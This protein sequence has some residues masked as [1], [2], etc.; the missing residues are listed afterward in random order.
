MHRTAFPACHRRGDLARR[1]PGKKKIPGSGT[2]PG[3]RPPHQDLEQGDS[4]PPNTQRS[5]MWGSWRRGFPRSGDSEGGRQREERHRNSPTLTFSMGRHRPSLTPW[6]PVLVHRPC[7]THQTL[8]SSLPPGAQSL[9]LA[10]LSPGLSGLQ[11]KII[12]GWTSPRTSQTLLD[13]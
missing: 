13:G 11:D 8:P 10:L 9:Y 1:L 12:Q 5:A 2:F 6:S 7:H 3:K 4:W